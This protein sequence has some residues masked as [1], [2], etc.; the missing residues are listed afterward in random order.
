MHLEQESF[1]SR[2]HTCLIDAQRSHALSFGGVPILL[3][4]FRFRAIDTYDSVGGD[5]ADQVGLP[6][7]TALFV[8]QDSREGVLGASMMAY[9]ILEA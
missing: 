8:Q 5:D 9:L 3:S 4:V 6:H 2:S 1:P 7:A